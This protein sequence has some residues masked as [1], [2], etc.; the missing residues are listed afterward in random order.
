MCFDVVELASAKSDVEAMFCSPL[1]LELV[2]SAKNTSLIICLFKSLSNMREC[3]RD[4]Y[5]LGRE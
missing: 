3:K 1:F 4:L 5:S 2:S